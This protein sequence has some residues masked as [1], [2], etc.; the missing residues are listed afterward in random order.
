[1]IGSGSRLNARPNSTDM[2]SQ[3]EKVTRVVL[4]IGCG[5][6]AKMTPRRRPSLAFGWLLVVTTGWAQTATPTSTSTP[7]CTNDSWTAS[8][9]T[10]APG[11]RDYHTAVWTVSEMIV[12]GGRAENAGGPGPSPGGTPTPTATATFTPIGDVQTGRRY[13][14]GTDTWTATSTANAP[15][16]RHLHTAIWTG[17]EM[18]VWGGYDGS[19]SL[20][21]GGRYNLGTD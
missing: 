21:T 1:M 18:I 15:S 20:N 17:S 7:A 16:S 13:N 2:A 6:F 8:S 10:N 4:A 11:A 19:S 5:C 9:T 14:P 3:L 12:W